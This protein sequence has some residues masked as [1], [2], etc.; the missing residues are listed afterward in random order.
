MKYTK[1][2][3]TTCIKTFYE[4]YNRPPISSDTMYISISTIKRIFGTFN[5][6]IQASNLIPMY[7]KVYS[8]EINCKVCNK[9]IKRKESDKN[10]NNNYFCS[11]TCSTTFNNKNKKLNHDQKHKISL[12]LKEYHSKYTKLIFIDNAICL[13]CNKLFEFKYGCKYKYCSYV[14]SGKHSYK[15]RKNEI[16]KRSKNEIY[17]SELCLQWYNNVLTNIKMFD[18]WDADI[19]LTDQKVAIAWNGSV[20]YVNIWKNDTLY[21]VQKRDKI[22]E[23]AINKHNYDLYVIKDLGKYNIKFVQ[24]QFELFQLMIMEI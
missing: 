6:A 17:F 21:K 1:D 5:N 3:I 19:I 7:K 20:H 18:G 23:E 13:E 2:C 24:E 14:C 16:H 11:H 22:K 9:I 15:I 12:S 8:F 4:T 10:Q